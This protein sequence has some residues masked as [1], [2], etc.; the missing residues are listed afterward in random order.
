MTQLGGRTQVDRWFSER[1]QP[2]NL[3]PMRIQ[4][5]RLRCNLFGVCPM[6]TAS[7]ATATFPMVG[8]FIVRALPAGAAFVVGPEDHGEREPLSVSETTPDSM[9]FAGRESRRQ[10]I[11]ANFAD[12]TDRLCCLPG[13]ACLGVEQLRVG[14]GAARELAANHSGVCA[15]KPQ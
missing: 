14:F 13:L 12:S 9:W 10:A 8:G 1:R 11:R 4:P 15:R 7:V 2:A 5:N 6:Q 3:Q